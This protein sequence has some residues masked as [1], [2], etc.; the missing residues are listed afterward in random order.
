MD[1]EQRVD[2]LIDQVDEVVSLTEHGH[3]DDQVARLEHTLR[4]MLQ[5]VEGYRSNF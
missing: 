2:T 1:Q 5:R 3:L 4:A